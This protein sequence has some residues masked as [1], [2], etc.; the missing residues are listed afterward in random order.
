MK[1]V[2]KHHK[3]RPINLV[4]SYREDGRVRQRYLGYLGSYDAAKLHDADERRRFWEFVD[5]KLRSLA[6]PLDEYAK[7]V[8]S[9]ERKL[10][11]PSVAAKRDGAVA[12]VQIDRARR[13]PRKTHLMV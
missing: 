2:A 4:A 1:W 10:P 11:R 6:L 12:T 5:T 9:I 8:A 7:I 13:H 3:R